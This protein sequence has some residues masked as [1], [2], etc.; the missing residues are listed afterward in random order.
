[1]FV[2][3]KSK[4]TFRLLRWVWIRHKQYFTVCTT[5]YKATEEREWVQIDANSLGTNWSKYKA[6]RKKL[7]QLKQKNN[8][9]LSK[10]FMTGVAGD[11]WDQAASWQTWET[12]SNNCVVFSAFLT[13]DSHMKTIRAVLTASPPPSVYCHSVCVCV[14]LCAFV[15]MPG[16]CAECFFLGGGENGKLFFPLAP[17]WLLP[18]VSIASAG[19]PKESGAIQQ[20]LGD[21]SCARAPPGA[22]AAA[23]LSAGSLLYRL[24]KRWGSPASPVWF[25]MNGSAQINHLSMQSGG[26][27]RLLWM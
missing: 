11:F 23:R 17:V 5:A 22:A 25:K 12:N 19:R 9:L 18:F 3:I 6:R 8:S 14:C 16:T 24:S 7:F 10:G 26:A 21:Y 2:G 15:C 4:C 13:D 20:R 1:M 27:D